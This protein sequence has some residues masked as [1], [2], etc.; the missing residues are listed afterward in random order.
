MGAYYLKPV[1]NGMGAP[2]LD[3]HGHVQGQAFVIETK[4]PG[5]KPTPRQLNTM[6]SVIAAGGSAFVI[7]GIDTTELYNWLHLPIPGYISTRLK[8][9]LK[10]SDPCST[11]T[12]EKI[13]SES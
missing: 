11:R 10:I 3:Y 9:F 6:R 2:A 13:S 4:A 5:A 1:Q 8:S 12:T 7:D